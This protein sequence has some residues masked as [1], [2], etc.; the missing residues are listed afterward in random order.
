MDLRVWLGSLS[1]GQYEAAFRDNEIH[2][3]VLPSLTAEDFKELGVIALGHRL[4]LLDAIA[5]LR[6]DARAQGLPVT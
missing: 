3:T 5:A 2:E 1:L 4:R 6:N